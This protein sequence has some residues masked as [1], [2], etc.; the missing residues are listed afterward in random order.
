MSNDPTG[1]QSSSP[2]TPNTSGVHEH[3]AK[4]PLLASAAM[5][6]LA[7]IGVAITMANFGIVRMYWVVL[8]P[9]YGMLSIFA[10]YR[11][12]RFSRVMVVRQVF[13]WTGIGVAIYLDL[14]FLHGAGEQTSMATGLSSLLLLALGCYLAGINMEWPFI[15]VG[16]FLTLIFVFLVVA[17]EYMLLLLAVGAVLLATMLAIHK[18]MKPHSMST[19][20][21]SN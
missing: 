3:H 20:Q 5:I 14:T 8:V 6:L 15:V 18:L 10:A 16:V 7:L 12:K 21:T 9:V 4:V 2:V 1:K 17:Q 11:D 13:H 19:A